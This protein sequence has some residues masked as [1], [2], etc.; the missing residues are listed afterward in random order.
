MMDLCLVLA[1]A[2]VLIMVAPINSIPSSLL[3]P[4]TQELCATLQLDFD[5]NKDTCQG[6]HPK[7]VQITCRPQCFHMRSTSANNTNCTA[8]YFH[9]SVFSNGRCKGTPEEH[10]YRKGACT[11]GVQFVSC[12]VGPCPDSQGEDD[13]ALFWLDQ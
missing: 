11:R 1:I 9:Q 13:G 7:T 5:E 10:F 6:N 4:G 2:L 3:T 12:E 8:E